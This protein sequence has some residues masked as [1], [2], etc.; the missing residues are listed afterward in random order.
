MRRQHVTSSIKIGWI[1]KENSN[2]SINCYLD[3]KE[4]NKIKCLRKFQEKLNSIDMFWYVSHRGLSVPL[5][6]NR[7]DKNWCRRIIYVAGP[8]AKKIL[9]Y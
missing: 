1:S 3:I 9:K 8:T 7:R 4:L 5:I 6:R 2:N